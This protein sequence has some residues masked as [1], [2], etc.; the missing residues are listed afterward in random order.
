MIFLKLVIVPQLY[1]IKYHITSS[2]GFIPVFFAMDSVLYIINI[3]SQ[4]LPP[5]VSLLYLTNYCVP[6]FVKR[7][8]HAEEPTCPAT[9]EFVLVI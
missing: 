5:T 4:P 7:R 6:F 3:P 8:I 2:V 1:V 9:N